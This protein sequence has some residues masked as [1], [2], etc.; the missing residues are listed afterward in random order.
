[1]RRFFLTIPL[2]LVIALGC[3]PDVRERTMNFFFEIPDQTETR[4]AEQA[5][6]PQAFEPAARRA[7]EPD[8]ASVH[9]PVAERNC[10]ACHDAQNRQAGRDDMMD[11][12]RA[13]HGRFFSDEVEHGPVAEGECASCHKPHRSVH[14]HLLRVSVLEGC[15]ECHDEPEDLSEEAHSGEDVEN[16]TM[17]HDPHFGEAPFLKP[18][19]QNTSED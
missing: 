4:T 16:C 10:A 15:S 14:Q 13:C 17:C 2:C 9:Q 12:C 8:F 7:P 5:K 19:Y 3:S 11:S 6:A 1:M 18:S